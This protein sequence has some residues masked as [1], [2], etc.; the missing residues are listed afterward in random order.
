MDYMVKLK[1]RREVADETMEFTFDT[2]NIDFTFKPGQNADWTLIDPPHTDQEGSTR[3]FSFV[4]SPNEQGQVRIATRMRDTAFKNSLKEIPIGTEVKMAGPLGSFTLHEN[5]ENMG[6]FLGGG[7]GITPMHSIL[8]FAAEQ[9]LPH[10]LVL[11]YSNKSM[12]ST[13]YYEDF[14]NLASQNPNFTF[15]PTLT[16]ETPTDWQ[17]ETGVITAEM[18]QKYVPDLKKAIFYLSGPE[19]MIKAMREIL[20][21]MQVSGD[22]IKTEEFSGY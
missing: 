21:G 2:S 15:V 10:K 8:T 1:D 6:V 20:D 17:S 18:I 14:V 22:N 16:E 4:N 12:S 13:A 5:I 11:L 7:I 19:G 9:K 3:T